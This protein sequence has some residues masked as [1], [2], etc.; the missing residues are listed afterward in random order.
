MDLG[1]TPKAQR[2]ATCFLSVE[3]EGTGDGDGG[4]GTAFV[5]CCLAWNRTKLSPLFCR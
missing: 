4:G 2:P 5:T 3:R 1:A